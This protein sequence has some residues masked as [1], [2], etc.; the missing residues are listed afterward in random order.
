MSKG[1]LL[2]LDKPDNIKRQFGVGYKLLIEPNGQSQDEFRQLKNTRIDSILKNEE[3]QNK[4]I[5]ENSD[6]TL[7]KLIYQVPFSEVEYLS[8]LLANLERE[9]GTEVYIDIEIN[10]LED[11]YI[12]IAKEEERLLKN[13]QKYG[14][15]RFS[16]RGSINRRGS[17][18]DNKREEQ[19]LEEQHEAKIKQSME[20][21]LQAR[22]DP[23][24]VKQLVANM[25]RRI[26]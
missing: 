14:V 12:N 16:M 15:Q 19:R 20:R 13:L 10:N 4:G 1:Q 21:Y 25:K 23:T 5:K 17:A 9:F 6:S 7:K 26:I 2:A 11:A 24:F 8:Q 3:N 22:G 18:E